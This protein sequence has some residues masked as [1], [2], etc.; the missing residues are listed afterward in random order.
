MPRNVREILTHSIEDNLPLNQAIQSGWINQQQI[1]G[2]LLLEHFFYDTLDI[3]WKIVFPV[4]GEGLPDIHGK[5][6]LLL[7][8][9]GSCSSMAAGIPSQLK[10]LFS[11]D[12]SRSNFEGSKGPR[13]V[14]VKFDFHVR[15]RGGRSRSTFVRSRK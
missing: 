15:R 10:F 3:L 12:G 6:C 13:E 1:R 11:F 4:I 2:I 9:R 7:L 14:F 8:I 5:K